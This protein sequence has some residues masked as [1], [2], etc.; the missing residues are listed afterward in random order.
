MWWMGADESRI[1]GQSSL[2][3]FVLSCRAIVIEQVI[4]LA[5][6]QAGVPSAITIST[7]RWYEASSV[8]LE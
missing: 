6:K 8:W 4:I 7:V 2:G 1:N 3:V 5:K